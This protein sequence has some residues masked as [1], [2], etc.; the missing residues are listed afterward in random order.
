M[1]MCSLPNCRA[2]AYAVYNG[3]VYCSYDCFQL[4]TKGA[5]RKSF[6][7]IQ[8]RFTDYD[9]PCMI[10]ESDET[11]FL[12]SQWEGGKRYGNTL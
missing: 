4:K 7:P 5:K 6:Y 2:T 11:G 12:L 8:P 9:I 10:Y 1:V 3:K